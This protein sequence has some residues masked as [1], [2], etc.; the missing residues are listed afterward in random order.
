MKEDKVIPKRVAIY[1][2]V[3]TDE[4]VERYG[5]SL[6]K[7]AIEAL[8]KSKGNS[9]EPFIFAGEEH[10]YFDDGVSGTV[11]LSERPAFARLIEAVTLAPEGQKPFDAVAVYKIDRF[12]RKLTVLLDAISFFEECGLEFLSVNESIDTSTPFGKAMLGIIGVIAELER[13]T[14]LDRTQGGRQQALKKGVHMGNAAPYGF[15]KD[16]EKRLEIFDKEAEV[17][18]LIFQSLVST[19]MSVYDIANFLKKNEYITPD[20]S[21]VKYGKRKG[22][23]KNKRSMYS[24]HPEV[25]RRMIQDEIYVGKAY[26]N[27]TKNGKKLPKEDWY[28]TR[29]PQIIDEVTFHKAQKLLKESKHQKKITRTNHTYL[30]SGLMRCEACRKGE[31]AKYFVGT[32]QKVK[33]TGN[34]VYYYVCKGKSHLYKDCPC[35]TTPIPADAIEDYVVTVCKN[36]LS[37]PV[38]TFNYQKKLQSTRAAFNHLRKEEERILKLVAGIPDRKE[39]LREQHEVG[40]IDKNELKRRLGELVENEKAHNKHL[41]EVHMKLSQSSLSE[42]YVKT[43]GLF[44]EKYQTALKNVTSNR[45][46]VFDILH[47][48]IDEITVYSRPVRESDKIA[49]RK[50]EGQKI[51]NRIHI[52]FKL[53]QEMLNAFG[54]QEAL[55]TEKAPLSG[56]SSGQ[57]DVFG[58]R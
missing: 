40:L 24:W 6:Q 33:S 35:M 32:N 52:K 25:I 34:K 15:T 56:A 57:E 46:E 49:G 4:Q 20:E 3:S 50:K 18:Q 9:D 8:I 12:A 10:V 36:I 44:N 45:E 29:V 42:A 48:M 14:I 41:E 7:E 23:S 55:I 53:P 30:L 2:R 27:K 28:L 54:H 38:D 5:A 39:K 43:L 22:K 17:V 37:N 47:L 31:S 11:E 58:A 16:T 51:P 26:Y 13:D 1:L 21:A 19:K